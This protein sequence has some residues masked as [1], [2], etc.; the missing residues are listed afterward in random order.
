MLGSWSIQ[1]GA[2]SYPRAVG[3]SRNSP[4][5]MSVTV[6]LNKLTEPHKK[7]GSGCRCFTCLNVQLD[8]RHT[9]AQNPQTRPECRAHILASLLRIVA[10]ITCVNKNEPNRFLG[11]GGRFRGTSRFS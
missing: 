8:M 9:Q 7:A 6:G 1:A 5:S 11:Y 2:Q 4:T 10:Y 3:A